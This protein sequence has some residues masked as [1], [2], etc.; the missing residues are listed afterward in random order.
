[1]LALGVAE[2]GGVEHEGGQ[3]FPLR[4]NYIVCKK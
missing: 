3:L 4:E 1:M 2:I